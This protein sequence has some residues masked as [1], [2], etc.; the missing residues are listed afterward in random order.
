M[1]KE[2]QISRVFPR[3]QNVDIKYQKLCF[4]MQE[5]ADY[6]TEL[7][8]SELEQTTLIAKAK[9]KQVEVLKEKIRILNLIEGSRET[10]IKKLEELLTK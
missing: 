5:Y 3:L 8:K 2:E 9:T 6:K 7:L 4:V 1:T 10:Y